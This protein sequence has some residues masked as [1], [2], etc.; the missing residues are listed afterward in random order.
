MNMA[1]YDAWR[2]GTPMVF[3]ANLVGPLI[4]GAD[5]NEA[6]ICIPQVVLDNSRLPDLTAD[7][8]PKHQSIAAEA[9]IDTSVNLDFGLWIRSSES[10]I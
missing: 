3:E 6:H 2:A 7:P 4:S 10:D 5:Y 8:A 1:F 9:I